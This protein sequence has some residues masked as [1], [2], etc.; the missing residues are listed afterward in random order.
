MDK[1]VSI[2]IFA[3]TSI[4]PAGLPKVGANNNTIDN[5]LSIFF[6]IIGA[7][8]VLMIVISGLRYVLAGGDSQRAAQA[9]SGIVYALVGL[10]I[11]ISA[12]AI[13]YFVVSRL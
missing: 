3:E 5:I 13:V 2:Y 8:A 4:K 11:A 9:K 7:L 12:Q 6:G 1:L 10:A